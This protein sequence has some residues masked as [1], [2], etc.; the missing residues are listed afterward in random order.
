MSETAV[1][2]IYHIASEKVWLEA[3]AFGEYLHPSLGSEGFIHC[4]S[5]SQVVRTANRYYRGQSGLVLLEIDP[6]LTASEIRYDDSGGDQYPHLYGPLNLDAVV[7]VMRFPPDED[8]SFHFPER[9]V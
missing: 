9:G 3:L 6:A 8:G 2:R 5:V 7:D 4:S 1:D